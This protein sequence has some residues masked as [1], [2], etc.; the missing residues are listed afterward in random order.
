M[1]VEEMTRLYLAGYSAGK[2]AKMAGYKTAKSV[3]DKL[4]K[5]GVQ[6]R[7]SAQ[8]QAL[9]RTYDESMFEEIDSCW[10]AYF[11]GLLLTDGWT[12]TENTVGWSSV[13]YDAVKFLSDCT[14]K[15][16]QTVSHSKSTF[17]NP[18]GQI[19]NRKP[20]YRLV[21]T[22]SKMV[23]DVKR[24]GIVQNK[25]HT[26]SG[27]ELKTKE[28]MYLK[29]IVRGI[30]DGDGTLGFP[31]NNPQSM[32]FR[33]TSASKEFIDWCEWALHILGMENLRT[34]K[35]ADKL[36]ELNSGRPENIRVLRT[37]YA[38][39]FGM[40]RKYKK[41]WNHYFSAPPNIGE[42]PRELLESPEEGNQQPSLGSDPSEGSTTSSHDL[43]EIMKDHERAAP[44][45]GDDIV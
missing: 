5:A 34:R 13:D 45:V 3:S 31:S 26:L 43:S 39:P 27:P 28:M 17:T 23:E 42:K 4:K 21:F 38:K 36:W 32:Y 12:T 2:I 41:I 19:C 16:I 40:N 11:L 25:T 10:K 30:I 6:M 44:P 9:K 1:L 7:T 35:A 15:S 24:L 37:I 8:S 29:Y 33:I 22:S 20:E 18:Q 14:G